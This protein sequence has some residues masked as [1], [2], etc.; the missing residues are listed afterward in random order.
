MKLILTA[1]LIITTTMVNAQ[2]KCRPCK[3]SDKYQKALAINLDNDAKHDSLYNNFCKYN[4][5][6]QRM[7]I[8]KSYFAIKRLQKS[9]NKLGK[10]HAKKNDPK[11]RL[12]IELRPGP[13]GL[14]QY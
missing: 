8:A 9:T 7:L 2:N 13:Y 4:I 1:I 10:K 5:E 14:I 3:L 6:C 12:Q 11:F